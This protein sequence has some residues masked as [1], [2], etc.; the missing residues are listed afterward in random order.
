M[1]LNKM[2]VETEKV[3]QTH[4]LQVWLLELFDKV[5]FLFWSL[6]TRQSSKLLRV[7]DFLKLQKTL[8]KGQFDS[9]CV[10]SSQRKLLACQLD[11]H[12]ID[13]V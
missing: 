4:E 6:R 7:E 5:Q 10:L 9:L 8:E 3:N 1:Y 12:S 2:Q 13:F 11:C